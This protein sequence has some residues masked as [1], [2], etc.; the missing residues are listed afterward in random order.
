M[1][2]VLDEGLDGGRNEFSNIIKSR[3]GEFQAKVSSPF[4]CECFMVKTNK[5]HLLVINRRAELHVM[6][7]CM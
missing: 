1:A 3:S 2:K 5:C 4:S 7:K 6:H